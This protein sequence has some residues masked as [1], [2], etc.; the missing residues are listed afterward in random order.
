M[1]T[2]AV[3]SRVTKS[4]GRK[5]S[6]RRCA[7]LLAAT[8]ALLS[9]GVTAL[10]AGAAR[11]Q[12][13]MQPTAQP[14][15]RVQYTVSNEA[16]GAFTGAVV[17]TNL[18]EPLENWTLTWD[19]A[20]GQEFSR[21][22]GASVVQHGNR[23]SATRT[24]T[25][26]AAGATLATGGQARFGVEGLWTAT[27]PAPR[28][29]ALN[30]TPCRSS[31]NSGPGASS[32]PNPTTQ[33]PTTSCPAAPSATTPTATGATPRAAAPVTVWLAG[34]STMM[35]PVGGVCPV[36]WGSQFGALFGSGATVVNKAVGGRS[37]QTWLYEGNVSTTMG[38]SG[39]CV[40][41]PNTYATRWLDLLSTSTGMKAG[42]YLLVAF[43]INDGAATCARHVGS[44]RYQELL[45]V[46]AKAAQARGAHPIFLTPTAAITCSGGTATTNR[47][48]ITE[49][50][51][52]GTANNVPVID[53][54]KLSVA[55]YT[56]LGF[57]PNNGDYTSGA[58]GAFF[59][60]DH[61]HFETAGAA[62]I[63]TLV[64]TAL[65]NQGIALASLLK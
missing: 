50:F 3:S 49:T 26:T 10:P 61:T 55:L 19:V 29:F 22:Q 64:A 20:A 28:R 52:A 11:A 45:G 21:G 7:V 4:P 12:T 48:F 65:R 44:A 56:S 43:G 14:G 34:D 30:G 13:R 2:R 46:M 38:S 60:N 9:A 35:N 5:N 18:G 25:G 31:S 16:E 59:C 57:C 17:V 47:G 53:L 33:A 39:E 58:L 62:K 6:G 15:C 63:A 24:G 42:D 51:A 40:I 36:G 37:I 8:V 27:N 32:G 23:V 54:Q 41:N 1:S